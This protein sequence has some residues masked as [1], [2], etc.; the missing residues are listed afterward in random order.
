MPLSGS[1]HGLSGL[2]SEGM[3]EGPLDRLGSTT[4]YNHQ[5]LSH[6]YIIYLERE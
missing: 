6:T 1:R 4:T 3:I 2:T 5:T